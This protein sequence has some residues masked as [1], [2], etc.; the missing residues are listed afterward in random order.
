MTP[1]NTT[2]RDRELELRPGAEDQEPRHFVAAK[3]LEAISCRTKPAAHDIEIFP[4]WP[5]HLEL[6]HSPL[7][8]LWE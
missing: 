1:S 6:E 4:F 7:I 3:P 8:Q 2:A 5:H